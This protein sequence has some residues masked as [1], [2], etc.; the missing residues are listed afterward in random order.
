MKLRIDKE[1][2]EKIPPLTGEEFEQ[3]EANILAEPEARNT[4]AC[5]CVANLTAFSRQRERRRHYNI[6]RENP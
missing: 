3:L 4:A 2:A 5:M 1:F 6:L